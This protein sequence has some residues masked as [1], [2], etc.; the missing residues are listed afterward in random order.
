MKT[1]QAL[2]L[3]FLALSFFAAHAATECR[4]QNPTPTPAAVQTTTV[5]VGGPQ[6]PQS[7][8]GASGGGGEID[9]P[10]AATQ[11]T[12]SKP[13]AQD[14]ASKTA[15]RTLGSIKGRV[16]GDAGESLPGVVVFA[17]SRAFNLNSF[18]YDTRAQHSSTTD[19][20]GNFSIG[21][22]EP[23]LYGLSASIP[24]YVSESDPL[25]GNAAEIYRP[26]DAEP[27]RLGRHSAALRLLQYV[28]DEAHRFAQHY[29]HILRRKKL[30]EE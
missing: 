9:L 25:T 1:P 2:T 17:S 19:D 11:P 7:Q 20:E 23:G 21:S 29:H 4:A 10:Q 14:G 18:N 22:L 13:A 26:G 24:V 16:V 8:T 15:R 27:L 30:Q 6:S 5:V 3:S 12:Q 28:R